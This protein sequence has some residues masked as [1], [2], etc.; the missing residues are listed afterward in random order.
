MGTLEVDADTVRRE[1]HSWLLRCQCDST[2]LSA[3]PAQ[4]PTGERENAEPNRG[5]VASAFNLDGPAFTFFHSLF[6]HPTLMF[7]LQNDVLYYLHLKISLH[8]SSVPIG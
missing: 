2:M 7:L 8:Y 6:L 5:A 3:W 1:W 4:S